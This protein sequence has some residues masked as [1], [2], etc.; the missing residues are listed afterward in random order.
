M[1]LLSLQFRL[2]NGSRGQN[3]G[4]ATRRGRRKA[5][6]QPSRP[7]LEALEGRWAPATFTVVNIDD[8][9]AGSLRD[10]IAQ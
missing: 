1:S 2:K 9:G 7:R 4:R 5:A 10:A 6:D 3:A 8:G